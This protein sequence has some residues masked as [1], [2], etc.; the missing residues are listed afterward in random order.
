M[1]TVDDDSF[2]RLVLGRP[3]PV[4]VIFTSRGCIWCE[5]LELSLPILQ[6]KLGETI[7]IVRCPLQGSLRTFR[8]HQIHRTP[9][10]VLFDGGERLAAHDSRAT[11]PAIEEWVRATL[12]H[13]RQA[14][15]VESEA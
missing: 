5:A 4:L 8:R 7:E 15:F 11:I 12:E 2:S 14:S 1:R 6:A 3:R 9:T 10:L 13:R